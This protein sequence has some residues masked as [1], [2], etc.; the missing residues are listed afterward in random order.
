MLVL[1]YP[2]SVLVWTISVWFE[3]WLTEIYRLVVIDYICA[4]F[5]ELDDDSHVI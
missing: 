3:H 1:V 5:V 2:D 4:Y